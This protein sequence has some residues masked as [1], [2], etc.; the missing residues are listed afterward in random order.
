ML[1]LMMDDDKDEENQV[2]TWIE[3]L[4][5]P[6]EAKTV[7]LMNGAAALLSTMET[8]FLEQYNHVLTSR[9]ITM[10]HTDCDERIGEMATIALMKFGEQS[11]VS[12][13]EAVDVVARCHNEGGDSSSSKEGVWNI[14]CKRCPDLQ[15]ER[16]ALL[17]HAKI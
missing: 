7:Q 12:S 8:L 4:K 10:I 16:L 5:R 17:C 1:T 6:E 15:F 13:T 14:W 9:E 3:I 11:V 2:E